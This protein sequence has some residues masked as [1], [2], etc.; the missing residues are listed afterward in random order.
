LGK[1]NIPAAYGNAPRQMGA[2][3]DDDGDKFT[4]RFDGCVL[5]PYRFSMPYEVPDLAMLTLAEVA[6]LVAAR[7]LPAVES[8]Q[9]TN[10]GESDMRIASDGKWFHQGGEIRRPAMVRAFSSLLRREADGA[11]WLVT[12]HQKLSIMVDDA[13]FMAVEMQS[14]GEG[15][16]R[17]LAF[18]LNSDDLVLAGPEN[19]IQIRGD[20]PYLH[21]RAGLWAKIARPVF[22]EL[23]EIALNE[24]GLIE[25]STMPQVWSDG[26]AFPIGMI[27]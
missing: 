11:Y 4:A 16:S 1:T 14:E 8:W 23:V 18:R 15:Q 12:P 19:M 17:S 9:P 20:I 7:K 10:I 27:S 22:Y 24:M 13:P 6:E 3:L 25:G 5:W 2:I 26:S 21:V